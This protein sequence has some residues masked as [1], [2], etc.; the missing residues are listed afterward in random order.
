MVIDHEPQRVGN[1]ALES[2]QRRPIKVLLIVHLSPLEC[3]ANLWVL[4]SVD[5]GEL[6]E[7]RDGV[8]LVATEGALVGDRDGF[9]GTGV[10]EVGGL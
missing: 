3:V 8:A 7:G 5:D 6:D 1:V 4:V 10:V 9:D 2:H